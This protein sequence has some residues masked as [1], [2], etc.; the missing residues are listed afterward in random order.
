MV[1]PEGFELVIGDSAQIEARMNAWLAGEEA[2]IEAFRN[3]YDIYSEFAGDQIYNRKITKKE[4]P[5]ERFVGKTS[6][7]G[8][9]FNMGCS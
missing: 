8:L 9:G 4:N 6:I 7:L 3:G 1:A 2:L 5:I